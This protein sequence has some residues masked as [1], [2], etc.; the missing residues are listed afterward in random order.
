MSV[1]VS[2]RPQLFEGE[3]LPVR[4][5]CPHLKPVNSQNPHDGLLTDARTHTHTHQRTRTHTQAGRVLEAALSMGASSLRYSLAAH[6]ISFIQRS[7]CLL[8]RGLITVRI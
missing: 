5:R 3:C 1:R 6:V 4:N 2:F 8:C 7:I